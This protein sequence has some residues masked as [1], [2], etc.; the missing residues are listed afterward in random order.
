MTDRNPD[1]NER[2]LADVARLRRR[3]GWSIAELAT[4][5]QLELEELETILSGEGK[6]PLDVIVLLARGL[7]IPPG[8]LIDGDWEGSNGD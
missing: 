1:P 7:D 6:L 2:F 3:R 4:R 5:A 8:R